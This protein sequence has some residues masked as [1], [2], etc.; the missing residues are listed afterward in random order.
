MGLKV[1]FDSSFLTLKQRLTNQ[2]QVLLPT[3]PNPM[4]END[5]WMDGWMAYSLPYLS[6]IILHLNLVLV[7]EFCAVTVHSSHE[8]FVM[9][10]VMSEKRPYQMLTTLTSIP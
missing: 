9:C 5:G 7:R 8:I 10:A 2:G 4:S 3:D 6:V 1:E